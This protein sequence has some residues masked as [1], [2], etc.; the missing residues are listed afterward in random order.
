MAETGHV[1]Q[2]LVVECAR[3]AGIADTNVIDVIMQDPRTGTIVLIMV[4]TRRWEGSKTQLF[5]LA[6]KIQTYVSFAVDGQLVEMHPEAKGKKVR[7]A[8]DFQ[9]GGP[10]ALTQRNLDS[11]RVQLQ[12]L[13]LDLDVGIKLPPASDAELP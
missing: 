13:G 2:S 12:K 7:F 3:V 10:D 6:E 9:N 11:A 1:E 5:E 4:E 8:V